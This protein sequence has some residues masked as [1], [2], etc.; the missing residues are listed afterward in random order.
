MEFS[1]AEEGYFSVYFY[2]VDSGADGKGNICYEY[3]YL[4]LIV[5]DGNKAPVFD[6]DKENV[7]ASE[8]EI[9]SEQIAGCTDP[10]SWD[11]LTYTL[12]IDGSLTLPDCFSFDDQTRTLTFTNCEVPGTF[13]G[14]MICTDDNFYDYANGDQSAED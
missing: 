8:D 6:Q 3:R 13:T 10:D 12:E 11:T 4:Y 9:Y 7:E 5:Q 1:S 2:V 14:K